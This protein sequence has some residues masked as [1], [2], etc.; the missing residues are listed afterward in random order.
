MRRLARA[1]VPEAADTL[2]AFD[3]AIALAGKLDDADFAGVATP[4][5]RLKLE[6]LQNAVRGVRATALTEMAP[7][8]GVGIGFNSQDGD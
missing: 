1:L 5:G 4:E 3:R 7:A 8:L 2:A 6:I